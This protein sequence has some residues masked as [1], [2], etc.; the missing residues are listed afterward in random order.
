MTLDLESRQ[1]KTNAH[2]TN[3][4]RDIIELMYEDAIKVVSAPAPPEISQKTVPAWMMPWFLLSGAVQVCVLLIWRGAREF[5]SDVVGTAVKE[6]EYNGEQKLY[7]SRGVFGILVV[8]KCVTGLAGDIFVP[9]TP[10]MVEDF[11]TTPA[12]L[13]LTMQLNWIFL[14][15]GALVLGTLSDRYG[16]R[17][18]ILWAL[19]LFTVTTIG[20]GICQNVYVAILLRCIEGFAEGIWVLCEAICRDAYPQ[21]DERGKWA[22]S[23][24]VISNL[25][26]VFAPALGGVIATFFGWRAVFLFLTFVGLLVFVAAVF[27]LP[28]TSPIICSPTATAPEAEAADDSEESWAFIKQEFGRRWFLWAGCGMFAFMQGANFGF[29]T[30]ANYILQNVRGYTVMASSLMLLVQPIAGLIASTI[31]VVVISSKAKIWG[32]MQA[33]FLG[34]AFS[35]ASSL[36]IGALEN[37]GIRLPLAVI[38]IP[39]ISFSLS[40][41]LSLIPVRIMYMQGFGKAAGSALALA[42]TMTMI[43]Q[44]ALAWVSTAVTEAYGEPALFMAFGICVALCVLSWF[45]PMGFSEPPEVVAWNSAAASCEE[46]KDGKA[47]PEANLANKDPQESPRRGQLLSPR[48]CDLPSPRTPLPSP[49]Q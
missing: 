14:A 30:N 2:Q 29:A 34:L 31:V 11:N 17:P 6:G 45:A 1:R 13:G 8:L 4:S 49:R 46:G 22:G 24:D 27:L 5:G 12:M 25:S 18:V 10:Q 3:R 28:E 37:K 43:S 42:S 15:V 9:S 35:A 33:G 39:I 23:L 40:W 38:T 41:A 20:I 7:L 32:M 19:A 26:P 48:L 47:E 36:S 16:R 21:A 44:A